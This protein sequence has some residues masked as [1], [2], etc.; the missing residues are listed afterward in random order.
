MHHDVVNSGRKQRNS[1]QLGTKKEKPPPVPPPSPR[2]QF[3]ACLLLLLLSLSRGS[4]PHK[5]ARESDVVFHPVPLKQPLSYTK[6]PTP[7]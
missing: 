1:T 3:L 7:L 5:A 6:P 2:F 4:Q